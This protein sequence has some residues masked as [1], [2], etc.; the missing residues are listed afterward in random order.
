MMTSTRCYY[1]FAMDSPG[2]QV[3]AKVA[4]KSPFLWLR[5]TDV[6]YYV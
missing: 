3:V 6:Q 4:I 2:H 1:W 5:N